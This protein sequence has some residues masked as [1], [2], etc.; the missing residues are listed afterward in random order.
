[1]AHIGRR[2]ARTHAQLANEKD[3]ENECQKRT[4]RTGR[5]IAL[6]HRQP[7]ENVSGRPRRQN[8]NATCSNRRAKRQTLNCVSCETRRRRA[9]LW[10]ASWPTRYTPSSSLRW[11]WNNKRNAMKDS[12]RSGASRKI[13]RKYEGSG[14]TGATASVQ[15]P[16]AFGN[17]WSSVTWIGNF[18]VGATFISRRP[19]S[20]Q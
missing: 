16:R 13:P 11:R 6:R 18:R 1:M 17:S 2:R 4:D 20:C 7:P 12:T 8:T 14:S 15:P 3:G 9:S 5:S 10:R 19:A